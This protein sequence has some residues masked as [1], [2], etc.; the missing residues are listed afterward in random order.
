MSVTPDLRVLD[1]V[2]SWCGG[3]HGAMPLSEALRALAVG[4]GASAAALTRHHHRTEAAPRTVALFSGELVRPLPRPYCADVLGYHFGQAV[5][6]SLWLLSEMQDDP[7]WASSHELVTWCRAGSAREIAVIPIASSRQS[8]DYIE[9]HF[10]AELTRAEQAEL[11]ALVPTIE[12]SWKGRR[13]GLV[14]QT[15]TDSRALPVHRMGE[16]GRTRWQE[17][18][19]GMSNPAALSRAEFRVCHMLSRGLSVRAV[20]EELGLTETTVRSHLRAIYA[21]TETTSLPELIYLIMS[22]KEDSVAQTFA[23]H[24]A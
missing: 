7:G 17:A 22:V 16:G 15:I 19:L 5:C 24:R 21:K 2:A 8:V 11:E 18:I 1:G 10:A 23:T 13:P 6:G 3:L 20:S 9:L 4:L 14:A 12:R